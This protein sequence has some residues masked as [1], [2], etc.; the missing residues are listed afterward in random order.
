MQR[1]AIVP[2]LKVQIRLVLT[3]CINKTSQNIIF[4]KMA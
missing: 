3:F 2:V 1:E 4:I